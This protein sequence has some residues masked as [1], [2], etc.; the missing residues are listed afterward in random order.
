M[1]TNK[2]SLGKVCVTVDKDYWDIN[3]DYDKLVIVEV[4][5]A[6]ATYISRQ[7][8]P[9][10]IDIENKEYW[11]LFSR[12]NK[13]YEANEGIFNVSKYVK[14]KDNYE[15]PVLLTLKKAVTLCPSVVKNA[16]QVITFIDNNEQWQQYQYQ[17]YNVNDWEDLTKW[18]NLRE[19]IQSINVTDTSIPVYNIYDY[20]PSGSKYGELIGK[21]IYTIAENAP[22]SQY[23]C[24][25]GWDEELG[26]PAN[27]DVYLSNSLIFIDYDVW[28]ELDSISYIVFVGNE[29]DG[30]S[31]QTTLNSHDDEIPDWILRIFGD[32]SDYVRSNIESL[33]KK[34]DKKLNTKLTQNSCTI[35]GKPIA[36][37][38]NIEIDTYVNLIPKS[39][40]PY[41]LSW[42][43]DA[44]YQRV[45]V[46]D[47]KGVNV[48]DDEGSNNSYC[49]VSVDVKA[50]QHYLL[51]FYLNGNG[52]CDL[53]YSDIWNNILI[54]EFTYP[55]IIDGEEYIDNSFKEHLEFTQGYHCLSF[56]VNETTTNSIYFD[57]NANSSLTFYKP[58]FVQCS[59]KSDV[60]W[61][62][63]N[64]NEN[65]FGVAFKNVNYN[66]STKKIIFTCVDN[67]TKSID[68]TDFIKD[69]MVDTVSIIGDELVITFNT[70]S[71]KEDIKIALNEI[72]KPD[73]YYS[74]DEVDELITNIDTGITIDTAN[75]LLTVTEGNKTYFATLTELTAPNAPTASNTTFEVTINNSIPSNVSVPFT[76]STSGATI[77]YNI[78]G[79]WINGNSTTITHGYTNSIT[80]NIITKSIQLRSVK[81]GVYST[82]NTVTI[83]IKPK[84]AAGNVSVGNT[85]GGYGESVV[86]T[87]IPS[88]TNNSNSYFSTDSGVTWSSFNATHTVTATESQVAGKYRVKVDP[89]T[90]Y[91]SASVAQSTAFTLN[92][93][94]FY[95]GC[96]EAT[97]TSEADI[98][99]LT[100]GNV[101]KQDNMTGSYTITKE[102]N[103]Y[104]WFC[105]TGIIKG[106][107][108]GGFAVPIN[109]VV[110]VNGYN[111]YRVTGINAVAGVDTFVVS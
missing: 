7:P 18:V 56:Y 39:Y 95:Y 21:G 26:E 47:V 75:K 15:N 80:N 103:K 79:T 59:G 111:C 54:N 34:V 8:V 13:N 73:N 86:I 105:G 62:A 3:K 77:Q 46:G 83:T 87:F 109:S 94:K 102:L 93:K 16:G 50:K 85:D 19:N 92:K 60:S 90:D 24:T 69:G 101:L 53:Q 68:A 23:R 22:V 55:F 64:I 58:L 28:D 2:V 36:N 91:V 43:G 31:Y 65:Q 45:V 100:G 71:D 104:I 14:I 110:V 42:N 27:T 63:N 108:A 52:N 44:P 76:C 49:E 33:E 99:A 41:Q 20:C 96:G 78:N 51:S 67:T 11:C 97:L 17:G 5:N 35:Q 32:V 84:L 6:Y 9:H 66:K 10:G 82:I 107:T 106:I 12:Y 37:N 61:F 74:K 88:Q 98:K 25:F 89:V 70:D 1:K 30:Y 57:L 38:T 29:N 81:N 48:V 40:D 4:E 72:F